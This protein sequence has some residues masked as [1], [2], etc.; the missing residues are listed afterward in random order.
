MLARMDLVW[1][2]AGGFDD[3][4]YCGFESV[5]H[6]CCDSCCCMQGMKDQSCALFSIIEK[7]IDHHIC[8]RFVVSVTER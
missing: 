7:S 2:A 1:G 3:V 6:R 8:K 5:E 4:Q